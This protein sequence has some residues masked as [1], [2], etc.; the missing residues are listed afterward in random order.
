M[1]AAP[2]PSIA[3]LPLPHSLGEH[4]VLELKDAGNG[5]KPPLTLSHRLSEQRIDV[6]GVPSHR[7][8]VIGHQLADCF[9]ERA[10]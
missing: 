1:V 9:H 10:D 5:W 4:Y 2:P 3:G 8:T 6:F 7:W